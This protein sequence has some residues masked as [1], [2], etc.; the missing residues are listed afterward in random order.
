LVHELHNMYADLVI[1]S[2]WGLPPVSPDLLFE[3]ITKKNKEVNYE[4]T[5]FQ[6]F[7]NGSGT[8]R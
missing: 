8:I 5:R 4:R 2:G 3:D 7:P 6:S 1:S